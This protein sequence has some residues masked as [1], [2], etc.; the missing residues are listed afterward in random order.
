MAR[1]EIGVA[2]SKT[3]LGVYEGDDVGLGVG[4]TVRVG[5]GVKV[6]VPVAVVNIMASL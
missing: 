6:S 5:V 1:G 3:T 4:K 2:F